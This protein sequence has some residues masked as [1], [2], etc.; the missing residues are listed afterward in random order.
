M[1]HKGS[2]NIASKFA[3][4]SVINNIKRPVRLIKFIGSRTEFSVIAPSHVFDAD[5]SVSVGN[6]V[7]I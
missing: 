5:M 3:V 6:I 2:Q 1:V 7:N 4:I